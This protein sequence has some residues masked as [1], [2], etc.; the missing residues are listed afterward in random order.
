MKDIYQN[1]DIL[2]IYKLFASEN[3][4]DEKTRILDQ[5]KKMQDLVSKPFEFKKNSYDS[6]PT[7]TLMQVFRTFEQAYSKGLITKKRITK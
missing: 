1:Y 3:I 2:E 4:S 6:L 5:N 7:S